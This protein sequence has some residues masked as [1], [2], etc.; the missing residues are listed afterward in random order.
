[1][2]RAEVVPSS[3]PHADALRRAWHLLLLNGAHDSACGCSHD[4]VAVDVD[5][6]FAEA[7]AIA[8]DVIRRAGTAPSGHPQ[9]ADEVDLSPISGGVAVDGTPLRFF[10]EP[11]VGDL[12]NFCW[13]REG[14]RPSPPIGVEV[15]GGRFRLEWDGVQL[16]GRITRVADEPFV[17]VD[18]TI[19][20]AR[21]DHRLRLHVGLPTAAERAWAG[22]PF[23]VVERPLVGEG[24]E[25][26]APSPTWPARHVVV[27][28]DTAVF[29]E[30]VFEYEIVDGRAIAVTLLRCVG[31]ISRETLATRP[32]PAGPPTP[33]PG[34]QMLGDTA[35]RLGVWPRADGERALERWARFAAHVS[36]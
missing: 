22:S 25:G 6:R 7:R 18:G 4:Q 15:D 27:A 9:V 12:Y 13:A 2:E 19:H 32:W 5:A 33:T 36:P 23:E 31:T 34:A 28:S 3:A 1:M 20:N 10:D 21:E 29:H 14:Q 35:F 30:G 24:G 11:D 17:V 8:E 26:E 16:V